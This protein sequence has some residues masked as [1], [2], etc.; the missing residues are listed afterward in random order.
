[1]PVVLTGP[2]KSSCRS[3][4]SWGRSHCT[5]YAHTTTGKQK[6]TFCTQA[7]NVAAQ[8]ELVTATSECTA[9][10]QKAEEL[11]TK[12]LKMEQES[13]VQIQ[14]VWMCVRGGDGDVY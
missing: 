3:S 7:R 8:A 14:G 9:A 11:Y 4:C 2:T 1:M 10:Q 12:L 13:P 6:T 5:L